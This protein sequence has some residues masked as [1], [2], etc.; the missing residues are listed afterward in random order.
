MPL[1]HCPAEHG[2][3]ERELRRAVQHQTLRLV[4]ILE[5]DEGFYL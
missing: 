5:T 4:K 1:P 2:M 3:L